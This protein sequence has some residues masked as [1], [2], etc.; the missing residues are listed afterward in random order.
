M[1]WTLGHAFYLCC[2]INNDT[3]LHPALFKNEITGFS[4]MGGDLKIIMH[5]KGWET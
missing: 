5:S 1:P 3:L 2:D 4:D